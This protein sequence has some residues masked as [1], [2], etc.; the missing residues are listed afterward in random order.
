MVACAGLCA[1]GR[2]QMHEQLVIEWPVLL[3]HQFIIVSRKYSRGD[4]PVHIC[5]ARINFNL[6]IFEL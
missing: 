3:G 1:A 6:S 5:V 2:E 4:L